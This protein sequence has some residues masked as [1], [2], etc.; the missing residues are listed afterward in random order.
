M[1]F[2]ILRGAPI[3]ALCIFFAFGTACADDEIEEIVVTATLREDTSLKRVPASLAILDAEAIRDG[4]IQHFEELALQVPNLNFSGEGARARYF[5]VRGVGELE[6]YEGAPNAAVGFIVDDIDFTGIGGIATSFD[7]ERIEVLR[8]SQGTRYGANALGG[9]IYVQT[10]APPKAAEAT[11]ETLVGSDGAWGA[12]VAAGGPVAGSDGALGWRV[13]VQQFES[14]G[15]RQN[16]FLVRDDTYDRDELTARGKLRWKPNDDVQVDLVGM[17]VDLDNGY[18]AWAI[19]NSFT[20]QSD[21]PGQD[22]QQTG[23]GALRVTGALGETATLVSITG[24]AK[25]EILYSFDADWG[26]SALWA[27]DIYDF[28]QRTDRERRTLNQEL[29]LESGPKAQLP[30]SGDWI[31]GVYAM[32]LEELN[33]L[34]DLGLSDLDDAYCTLPGVDAWQCEPYPVDRM[35]DSAYDAT[36]LALFGEASWPLGERANVT[37][38]LRGER[39]DADYAD[40]LDDRANGQQGASAF[41]PTDRMWGG[42]LAFT[43]EANESATAFAR[44]ARGYRAGGFNPSLARIASGDPDIEFG[45]EAM[46]S[47]EVGIRIAVPQIPVTGSLTTFW[48]RRDNMQ[49]KVPTQPVPSDPTVFVFSTK[50]ADDARAYG[51]EG[52]FEWLLGERL[53]LRLAAAWL[54]SKIEQFDEEPSLEGHEFPHAPH[55]SYALSASYQL[56]AGWFARAELTGRSSFYFDY[57]ASTGDD[58]KSDPSALVGLRAGRESRHWRVEGWV[59][60][61][62]DEEY[63]VRGFY[64]GNEPP[65]FASTRYIRLGDPRQVGVTLTW[66]M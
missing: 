50:N 25:S 35:V 52:D 17:Y 33:T 6:Q 39:R 7:T 51:V 28:T 12:G 14:D 4:A 63:A 61:L 32:D 66:R 48:Q 36:S 24:V 44:I 40:T 21:R 45:D 22:A 49:V 2:V 9:L 37:F 53:N 59:R 3:L 27:P 18:D 64:F 65:D 11:V 5:Q 62:F 54:D 60:N 20:T 58:R 15:F 43:W 38:G 31:I 41:A 46:W 23:A 56:S 10:A 30:G 57:D 16:A 19:D 26:N 47:Y 29:R 55:L 8:G 13:A 34:T 42:E 1:S